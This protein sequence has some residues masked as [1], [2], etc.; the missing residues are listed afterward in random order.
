MENK[1]LE[2]NVEKALNLLDVEGG[3]VSDKHNIKMF[4][5]SDISVNDRIQKMK[6]NFRKQS[7]IYNKSNSEEDKESAEIVKTV[8][9]AVDMIGR[10]RVAG[11]SIDIS[12]IKYISAINNMEDSVVL[13]VRMSS[14]TDTR[15]GTRTGIATRGS[16][17]QKSKEVPQIVTVVTGLSDIQLT[18]LEEYQKLASMVR[19]TVLSYSYFQLDKVVGKETYLNNFKYRKAKEL[20]YQDRVRNKSDDLSRRQEILG[21]MYQYIDIGDHSLDL[22]TYATYS[23]KHLSSHSDFGN[24]MEN[25]LGLKKIKEDEIGDGQKV[26]SRTCPDL[27]EPNKANYTMSMK[28]YVE[29]IA[30]KMQIIQILVSNCIAIGEIRYKEIDLEVAFDEASVLEILEDNINNCLS[31][32]QDSVYK[33]EMALGVTESDKAIAVKE[34]F[35]KFEQVEDKITISDFQ[36]MIK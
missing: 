3:E 24:V 21:S 31:R 1:I 23:C 11:K 12:P 13:S 28:E 20:V 33:L 7:E 34:V 29:D 26:Y 35:N 25:D 14:V 8:V 27:V 4:D 10:A 22:S 16:N 30:D 32:E 19:N 36:G 18:I 15:E 17:G 5:L 2:L 9:G 6:V